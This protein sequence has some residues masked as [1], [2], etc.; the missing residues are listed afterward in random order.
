MVPYFCDSMEGPGSWFGRAAT[1]AGLEGQVERRALEWILAG[2]HPRT[3]ERL[4]STRGP[5]GRSHLQMGTAARMSD[6]GSL[7]YSVADVAVIAGISRT[8]VERLLDRADSGHLDEGVA[9]WLQAET[10]DDG[11]RMISDGE[12]QSTR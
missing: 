3:G 10:D 6:E 2:R 4:L 1:A 9:D 11:E 7:L 8:Q 5:G 12:L